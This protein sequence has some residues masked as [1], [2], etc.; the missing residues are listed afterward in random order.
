MS[1]QLT[2]VFVCL[3]PSRD[4]CHVGSWHCSTGVKRVCIVNSDRKISSVITQ[5][6]ALK[7]CND[8]MALFQVTA[9]A[10]KVT[11]LCQGMCLG[12][13]PTIDE[14]ARPLTAF[15]IMSDNVRIFFLCFSSVSG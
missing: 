8:N 5:S 11:D 12:P 15:R 6:T 4:R 9:A 2:S 7:F 14:H 13:A 1:F 3:S 10:T